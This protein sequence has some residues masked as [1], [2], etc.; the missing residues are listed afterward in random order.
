[1]HAYPQVY[2]FGVTLWE[3]M[4]RRRPYAGLDGFQIQTQVG[5][6]PSARAA[7]LHK[8]ERLCCTRRYRRRWMPRVQPC[9]RGGCAAVLHGVRSEWLAAHAWRRVPVPVAAAIGKGTNQ[10]P[11]SRPLLPRPLPSGFWTRSPC[12]CRAPPCRSTRPR[13]G[14]L[15]WRR[16]RWVGGTR[17]GPEPRP[18]TWIGIGVQNCSA[19]RLQ[20]SLQGIPVPALCAAPPAAPQTLVERCTRWDVDERPSFHDILATLKACAGGAATAPAGAAGGA[21]ALVSPPPA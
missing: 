4:E 20:R 19:A 18:W 16:W 6:T 17:W 2:A 1:M 21:E 7:A 5:A 9:S 13:R 11:P 15:S 14:G 3:L 12:G 8:G 10:Q